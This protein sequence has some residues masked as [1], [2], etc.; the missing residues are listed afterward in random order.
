[1]ELAKVGTI[2]FDTSD[3]SA[4]V[5]FWSEL[6][7]VEASPPVANGQFVFLGATAE[8][9]MIGFQSI[10]QPKAGKNRMHLDLIVGDLEAATARIEE[11]GGSWV[12]PGTTRQLEG[13]S[14][15][16]MADPEGNEFDIIAH[17]G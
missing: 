3:L 12:E 11:L 9:A 14:W 15:R 10:A 7:G 13:V 17:S 4:V 1:M 2:M 5:L 6:L 16:C 8:G